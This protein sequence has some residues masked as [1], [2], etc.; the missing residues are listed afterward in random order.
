M[1]YDKVDE[2]VGRRVVYEQVLRVD[3]QRNGVVN[4]IVNHPESNCPVNFVVNFFA[5]VR[6][7]VSVQVGRHPFAR[8]NA[9][10]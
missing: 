4:S 3:R 9:C 7:M 8:R 5:A 10:R 1:V 6:R 2:S